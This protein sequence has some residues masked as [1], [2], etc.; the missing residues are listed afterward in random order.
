M[1]SAIVLTYHNIGRP[2]RG[3]KPHGLYV[4]PEAFRLQMS[5]LKAAGFN[6]VSLDEIMDFINGRSQPRRP[7][8]RLV[9]LTFD[10]GFQDFSDNAW[11]VLKSF[12][13][14]ATVFVIA[15][16]AGG[17][18]LWDC[19][20]LNVRKKL[21]SWETIAMLKEDGAIFASHGMTHTS[22]S[23]L[24]GE[25]LRAE[26]AGSKAI[27][28]EKL[29]QRIDY[30]C[31][32]YGD[33]NEETAEA[34]KASGYRAAF[35]TVKGCVFQADNPYTIRRVSIK[36]STGPLAFAYKLHLYSGRAARRA[37]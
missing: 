26:V 11:P 12:G 21:L 19:D 13:F 25:A 16:L 9:A 31:Y 4:S 17:E 33:Y 1:D 24:T 15:E 7:G 14:A 5:Y 34:V 6:V 10:D 29:D 18:N 8:K 32:P 2:P 22:L 23:S 3:A 20:S 35:T 30:F 37:K 28:E 36:S 27:L